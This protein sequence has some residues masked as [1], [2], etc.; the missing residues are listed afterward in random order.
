MLVNPDSISKEALDH[1]EIAVDTPVAPPAQ[2]Q[3]YQRKRPVFT[4]FEDHNIS[5][6][7]A[8]TLTRNY[9]MASGK[10]AVK[11]RYFSRAAL[12]QLLMQEDT[13]G[14]RYYYGVDAEGRQQM[15]LVAVDAFGEDLT[16]GFVF[17]RA[18]PVSRFHE[19]HNPLNS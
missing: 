5:L 11:G 2:S 8:G 15:V 3:V 9:R 18:L 14:V 4:G 12:E 6:E 10:G 19:E 17:G 13:V 16:E 7:E 1:R